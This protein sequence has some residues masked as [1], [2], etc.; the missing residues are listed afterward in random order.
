MENFNFFIF[1]RIISFFNGVFKR[2]NT[3]RCSL[4]FIQYIFDFI[5]LRCAR[6]QMKTLNITENSLKLTRKLHKFT[7][8][9]FYDMNHTQKH[10]FISMSNYQI[11]ALD[12]C[13]CFSCAK[14]AFFRSCCLFC[15]CCVFY[16]QNDSLNILL[17]CQVEPFQ[18]ANWQIVITVQTLEINTFVPGK[19]IQWIG[20]VGMCAWQATPSVGYF[21]EEGYSKYVIFVLWIC[22]EAD[23][24]VRN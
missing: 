23:K 21:D 9:W 8:F 7:D 17:P 15:C 24:K 12:L 11:D 13:V 20:F 14:S 18:W 16:C 1:L 3:K 5:S 22:D 4:F 19:Q 10:R 2:V 6:Q